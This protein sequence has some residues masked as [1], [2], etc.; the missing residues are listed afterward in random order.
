MF[1][2]FYEGEYRKFHTIGTGIGLSLTKDLVTLH[3]GTINVT[4]D[5]ETGNTFTVS[6][7]ITLETYSD[8]EIDN[9]VPQNTETNK[10]TTQESVEHC[11]IDISCLPN[12][13][14][15]NSNRSSILIVEDNDE[16]RGVMH[17]LLGKYYQVSEAPD[18][19]T[20]LKILE[21]ENTDLVVSDVMM[22]GMN[23]KELCRHIKNEFNTSHL[24]VIL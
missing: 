21:M 5:T 22:P 13:A 15:S 2:R 3:H 9:E 14:N 20:A 16:L 1:E 12:I 17:R 24:P 8:E 10:N 6:L 11:P 7:P 4:S 23:R 19:P 18:G